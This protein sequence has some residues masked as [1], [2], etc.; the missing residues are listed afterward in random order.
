VLFSVRA[1]DPV[2]ACVRFRY[3]RRHTFD[4][5]AFHG[6]TLLGHV[7]HVHARIICVESNA[8]KNATDGRFFANDR[9]DPRVGK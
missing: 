6:D 9:D 4:Q 8:L 3:R 1:Q 7:H 5:D 2:L